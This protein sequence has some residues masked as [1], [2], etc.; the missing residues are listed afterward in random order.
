MNTLLKSILIVFLIIN[1]LDPL[2]SQETD[3]KALNKQIQQADISFYYDKDYFKAASLYEPL[4]N[5]YPENSNLAAKL[6]IC[7][8]NIEGKKKDALLLLEKA[9]KNIVS[10]RKEYSE[11]GEKASLDTYMYLALAYHANDSL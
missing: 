6:G 7:Y 9:S 5:A 8:L 10:E 3:K 2:L 1:S 11:Y 4:Y